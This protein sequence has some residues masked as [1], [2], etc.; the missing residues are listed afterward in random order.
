MKTAVLLLAVI[1]SSCGKP[2]VPTALEN[3]KARA[4]E[5]AEA[6]FH[7][8]QKESREL[9]AATEAWLAR[10]ERES[11]RIEARE[12]AAKQKEAKEWAEYNAS[13]QE[14]NREQQDY[15]DR[16]ESERRHDEVIKTLKEQR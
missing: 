4:K 13:R 7:A 3:A 1:L 8:M 14:I 5:Q 10:E 16:L 12:A 6:K 2:S 15:R 11:R 9:L